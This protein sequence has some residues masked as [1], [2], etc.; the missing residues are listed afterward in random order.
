MTKKPKIALYWCSGCGGCEESVID[1]AEDILK[2]AAAA[3]I[4][5]WPVAIDFKYK[6]VLALNDGEITATLINGAVRMGE[7]EQIAKILRKKS[8]LVIAHGSCAHLGGIVGLANFYKGEA[9]LSRSYKEVPTVK[10]PQG[11]LP[12]VETVESGRRLKLSGFHDHVKALDQVVDIDYYIPGCPPT[13]DLVQ[14]AIM[15]IL[16][17]RL[18]AR[19]SV[20]AEKKALCDT[21]PR[22]DS[23]PNRSRIKEFKRLYQTEWDPAKCFLDQGIICLGPATRGGCGARCINANMPCRGCF[24]PTDNVI[25]QGAKS[26]SFLASMIDSKDGETLKKIADSIPDPAG[27]FYKYSL[28]SSILKG[29]IIKGTT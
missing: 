25:D 23:R 1:L 6:D 12:K 11:T 19:G 20:L 15:M 26:L 24:G 16:E 14:N 2:V 22:R 29:K 21:C 17:D 13:P 3:D 18:P 4:V 5:F 7:Q 27:L 10:N 9:V 28:A 8:K